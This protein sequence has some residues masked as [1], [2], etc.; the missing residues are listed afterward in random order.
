[1]EKNKIILISALSILVIGGGIFAIVKNKKNNT[2]ST[3]TTSTENSKD[4]IEEEETCDDPNCVHDHDDEED[5]GESE[6][7]SEADFDFK[8][9]EGTYNGSVKNTSA[10]FTANKDSSSATVVVKFSESNASQNYTRWTMTVRVDREWLKHNSS[11]NVL[12]LSYS[13]CVCEDVE[14]N[15]SGKE[16]AKKTSSNGTGHFD[17]D[18]DVIRWS[19]DKFKEEGEILKDCEFKKI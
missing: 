18:D 6:D 1:M 17:I 4:K 5:E 13:D 10:N 3:P 8:E 19:D 14:V 7:E 2:D 16:K 15:A 12:R 11:S 9:V